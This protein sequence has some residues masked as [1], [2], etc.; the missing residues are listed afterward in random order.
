[1]KTRQ[2][3]GGGEV[4]DIVV[5]GAG[6][7]GIGVGAEAQKAGLSCLLLDRRGL[8][9]SM[10]DF[11]LDMTFF[12]TRDKLEIAEIPFCIPEDKPNRRQAISY[13]QGV[14]RHYGLRV[15]AGE[16]A[17]VIRRAESGL[18]EV[19]SRQVA[20]R[21]AAG[22]ETQLLAR[23]VVLAQGYFDRPRHLGVPGGDL[24]WVNVRYRE[25][26]GHFEQ[27]IL[28]VGAGNTAAEAALDL[29]RHGAQVTL[30]HRGQKIKSTVK[31]WLAPDLENR[32]AEGSI[33]GHFGTR[34]TSFEVGG[35]VR[36]AGPDGDLATHV[37][38]AYVL[39]GYDPETEL[40][41]GAGVFFEENEQIPHFDAETCESNVPGLYITGTLQAGRH[42]NRL[43]IE[44]TR[45]HADKV[46][47][48][49]QHKHQQ[50]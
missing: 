1:M 20:E 37:D 26:W 2:T 23:A 5:V 48:H 36:L 16:E 47:R 40:A 18:F 11:P 6:P 39:I 46:V 45:D 28:V 31:Y 27:H 21:P 42:T 19:Q 24:P 13:Y 4:W 35:E 12:T 10:G 33:A 44:N 49:L 3:Y 50:A 43:F 30:V 9:G 38:A 34:V 15:A 25:P 29:W 22:R 8:C 7:T 14:V 17:T 41:R 32:I